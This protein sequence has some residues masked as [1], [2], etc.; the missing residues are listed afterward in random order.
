MRFSLT[1][2]IYLIK[3]ILPYFVL[4]WLLLS[5][6]L[7][8]QQASRFSD[9]FFSVNIPAS[10]VWQL[11]LALIPNVIAFTCPMAVLVGVIIGLTKMQGD[12]ELIAIRAAG[13]GNFQISIPILVLGILLS[14]FAFFINLKGVPFAAAIVRQVALQTAIYKL[15]SPIEPGVFNTEVAGFTIYVKDGDIAEGTWKNIFI[16]N[17]DEKTRTV[18]LITSTNGRI[19]YADQLTE[20]VLENAVSSTFTTDSS[21]EKFVSESIG[22]VRYAVK[23]RRG[24][25]IEKLS[26]TE[27]TPDELGLSQLAEYA[28]SKDGRERTEAQILWQRRIILSITP[29]IF[30]LLG[31][32]LILRFSRKG[33]GFGIFAALLILISYYLLAFLGE[34]LARTERFSVFAGSLIPIAFSLL[35]VFWFNLSGK[36][37]SLTVW[38]KKLTNL[39][40][41][42]IF[43]SSKS[44]T[45]KFLDLSTGLRDFDIV[46][47][48]LKYY[49]LTL[50]FLS[51]VF[52]IFTAFELWKFAGT[53][54]NGIVLLLQYLFYLLP[55][56]YIQ[57]AP[58]AA[59]VC[60]L[61]TYVIKSRQN[62]IVTW[63][64]AGQSVY[65]LLL[66]CLLF[67]LLLGFLNWQIQE[68]ILPQSNQLQDRYRNQIR[69]RGAQAVDKGKFWVAN[70]KRIFSFELGK[71]ASDNENRVT[72]LNIYEFA[73]D[74]TR[75][76]TLYR[77]PAAVWEKDRIN[78]IGNYE[79]I[80]LSEGM[81]RAESMSGGSLAEVSNPFLEVRK[82]PSHLNIRETRQQAASSESEIEK[83][84]FE[85]A[86]EKK[87]TTLFL[88][89]VIALFTAPFALSLN[90]KGKIVTI[91]YAVGLWLLFMGVTSIF[92][93]FGLNGLLS[94]AFAV[95]SPLMLF[96]MFG[97]YLL[98]KVKT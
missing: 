58:S 35:A 90:R 49:L 69:S 14:F 45:G 44:K 60:T 24:E 87:Y 29:L 75:L 62:E 53:I 54:D 57:L 25:L 82:K 97:I 68:R 31:T 47:N 21:G 23:T 88:P 78:F 95:W 86:L 96:S 11:S 51:S 66:P 72:N 27:I 22:E 10:L 18:R 91:A 64:S 13:V 50:S 8:V 1:I 42:K 93:Q 92:D 17:E 2:S 4:S 71:N 74:K 85:V 30:C 73:D 28:K 15:E 9:I 83:R 32:A 56:I 67:M 5:V 77:I 63:T 65:R 61:A 46:I 98:A 7:F 41:K 6:I 36:L 3:T 80:D 37:G 43:K 12:S 76:Q 16:F 34:Q 48:L 26:S 39:F 70:D 20:L 52:I 79:R 38:V 19:D 55:F 84:S 94:P 89:F 81:I 59:M 33:R 40:P